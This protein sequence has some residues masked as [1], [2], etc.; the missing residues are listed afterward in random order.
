MYYLS[1]FYGIK[2]AIAQLNTSPHFLFSINRFKENFKILL[3]L[4]AL[5]GCAEVNSNSLGIVVISHYT[6]INTHNKELIDSQIH[7]LLTIVNK[8]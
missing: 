6:H 8:L 5:L 1:F 7:I 3:L 4:L 2:I